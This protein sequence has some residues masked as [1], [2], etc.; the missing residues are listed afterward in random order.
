MTCLKKSY[1]TLTRFNARRCRITLRHQVSLQCRPPRKPA[2]LKSNVS[3]MKG[4]QR[5][6]SKTGTCAALQF[7]RNNGVLLAHSRDAYTNT[8]ISTSNTNEWDFWDGTMLPRAGN[9]FPEDICECIWNYT[10]AR[11]TST[12]STWV[13]CFTN[14]GET[15]PEFYVLCYQILSNIRNSFIVGAFRVI[16]SF[17]RMQTAHL[18]LLVA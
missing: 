4:Q 18:S 13:N 1:Y 14:Q 11:A 7:L 3:D 17:H 6:T 9:C 16:L 5:V 15:S 2:G 8:N 12:S 10:R